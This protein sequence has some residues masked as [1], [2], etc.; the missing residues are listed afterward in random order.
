MSAGKA[1]SVA[2]VTTIAIAAARN[3]IQYRPE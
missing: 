3:P 2:A 1:V